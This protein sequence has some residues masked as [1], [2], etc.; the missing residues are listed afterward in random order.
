MKK[1]VQRM[2]QV[3]FLTIFIILLLNGRVQAW[4][5]L[6]LTGIVASFLFGRLY[7]GWI[8]SINTVLIGVTWIKEKLHIKSVPVPKWLLKSWLRYLA[9]GIFVA[10]FIFTVVT[11]KKLPVL[12][13]LFVIGIIITFIF[14]E[15]LWHRYLCP[16]GTML[17]L[18]SAK[19][20][21]GMQINEDLC[22]NCGLCSRVCPAKA[23][24]KAEKSHVIN[25][26]DCLVCMKCELNCR[27]N[28][29]FYK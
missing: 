18:S 29:I 28:A 26:P 1:N 7:C 3:L 12:P 21:H 25:E 9:F 22:N 17:H 5:G 19:A 6:L 10:I 4:M 15:E 2:V 24:V 16:Y 23:V 8:C 27:K 13:A 20:K 14:P 11:G